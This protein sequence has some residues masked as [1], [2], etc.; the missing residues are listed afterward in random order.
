[1]DRRSPFGLV[2]VALVAVVVAGLVASIVDRGSSRAAPRVPFGAVKSLLASRCS[3]CHPGV[4]ASLDLT[5][6]HAYRSIVGVRAVE[7]PSLPLVLAG[8]PGR[9]Y[10]YVKVAGWPGNGPNPIVGAR[11][12]FG[13]PALA[14]H[15]LATL[16]DW[17][18][19]GAPGDD[20]RTVSAGEVATPGNVEALAAA[21]APQVTSGDATIAGT[22]T[23]A[24]HRPLAGAIVTMLVV[25]R[26]LPGGEEHYLADVTDAA[27]RYAIHGAP[28]GRVE[29]KA[30][31]PGTVYVSH[32]LTTA[33]G[34][35]TRAD[36]GLPTEAARTPRIGHA[37]VVP[38]GA[39][40]LRLAMD[41]SGRNLDRNYT[42]AVNPDSGRVFE[43]R[44]SPAGSETPGTWT[45]LV[46]SAGLRGRWLFVAIDH[47]CEVSNVL[48]VAGPA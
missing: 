7:A 44:A 38:S 1:V 28:V 8:D 5:P 25:R 16:R 36:V 27:G 34:A 40:A 46:P 45:T 11:M 22:I 20:G 26:D 2:I 31:A 17:I 41:V 37:R 6:D 42:L 14:A 39:G 33:A 29:I 9:S 3:G 35:T 19:E 32:L 24:R 13:Q 48:E 23:D 10:L 43:L 15:D 30:Y 21:N 47:L 18:A 4:V 12:P